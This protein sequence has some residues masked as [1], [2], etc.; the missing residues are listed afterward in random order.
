MFRIDQTPA[1]KSKDTDESS[2][3]GS[4]GNGNG[5]GKGL[6]AA[7]Q[8]GAEVVYE[9]IFQ[10]QQDVHDF[11]LIFARGLADHSQPLKNK[12]EKTLEDGNIVTLHS[13]MNVSQL[14]DNIFQALTEVMSDLEQAAVK[15]TVQG[16]VEQI[17]DVAERCRAIRYDSTD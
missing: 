8:P 4:N 6:D 17:E 14:T 7:N 16:I 11:I 12:I 3:D 15:N 1:P 10:T 9:N 2:K 5:N 13:G